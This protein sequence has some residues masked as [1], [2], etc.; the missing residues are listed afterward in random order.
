MYVVSF[1]ASSGKHEVKYRHEVMAVRLGRYPVRL[2][3]EW[4]NPE[5]NMINTPT[6]SS[7]IEETTVR[8]YRGSQGL[9]ATEDN[10]YHCLPQV[11][12][13]IE[14]VDYSSPFRQIYIRKK[15]ISAQSFFE[16]W[17]VG[18]R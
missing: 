5:W 11:V 16:G 7:V 6:N 14:V 13:L 18:V 15:A 1:D 2:N 3:R 12:L 9:T 10:N 8:K 17:S 4:N